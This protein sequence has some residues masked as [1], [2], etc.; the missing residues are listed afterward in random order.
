[1]STATPAHLHW[2][3]SLHMS[4]M[5]VQRAARLISAQAKLQ[6]RT[7]RAYAWSAAQAMR[8]AVWPE[9]TGH[10]QLPRPARYPTE[11]CRRKL[12]AT[13]FAGLPPSYSK[14]RNCIE[15]SVLSRRE[16]VMHVRRVSA[17]EQCGKGEKEA[18]LAPDGDFATAVSECC[19]GGSV[20]PSGHISRPSWRA[21]PTKCRVEA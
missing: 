1:M 20:L 5:F 7:G 6:L 14:S 15:L 4:P 21:S 18:S 11:E 9:P 19:F 13:K 12:I 16:A 3:C 10:R 2:W 17:S 8:L